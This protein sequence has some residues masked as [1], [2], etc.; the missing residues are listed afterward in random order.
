MTTNVLPSSAFGLT[1]CYFDKQD[2]HDRLAQLLIPG[3]TMWMVLDCFG[4]GTGF[5]GITD[6]RLMFMD[7]SW[8]KTKNVI[9]SVPLD[10][11]HAVGISLAA[12][13]FTKGT[14]TLSIQAGDD[15]WTFAFRNQDKTKLAY[16]LLMS[17]V[18]N[19]EENTPDSANPAF[20]RSRS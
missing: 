11:V 2:Q 6:R 4:S 5:I 10:R 9:V 19:R 13:F 16:Q 14:G 3:E 12:G 20:D 8:R 1:E 15:D 7:S 18:L 17:L